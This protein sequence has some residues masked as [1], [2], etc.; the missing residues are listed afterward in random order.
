MAPGAL[1]R[2]HLTAHRADALA[3]LTLMRATNADI[4]R[5]I[6]NTRT[7]IDDGRQAI[8]RTDTLLRPRQGSDPDQKAR[9]RQGFGC[10]KWR[11]NRREPTLTKSLVARL[12]SG[13]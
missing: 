1:V 7:V 13:P 5:I 10:C 6:Q 3:N 9:F 2:S 4:H 12:V 11:L 8:R